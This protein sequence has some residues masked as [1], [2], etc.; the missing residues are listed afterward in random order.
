VHPLSPPPG[1]PSEARTGRASCAPAPINTPTSPHSVSNPPGGSLSLA[2]AEPTLFGA[3]E[4]SSRH[5][6]RSA[7]RIHRGSPTSARNSCLVRRGTCTAYAS[8]RPAAAC[9][10]KQCAASN[11]L[12]G[13]RTILRRAITLGEKRHPHTPGAS[14][15]DARSPPP[16]AGRARRTGAACLFVTQRIQQQPLLVSTTTPLTRYTPRHPCGGEER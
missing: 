10:H 4:A 8:V 1:C 7:A 6:V 16:A 5:C 2:T 14:E 11:L 9:R 15:R 13:A 3:I 12:R